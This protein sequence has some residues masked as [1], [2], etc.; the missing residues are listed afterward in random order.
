[1]M[2]LA[3]LQKKSRFGGFRSCVLELSAKAQECAAA[4]ILAGHI[5]VLLQRQYRSWGGEGTA[6]TAVGAV[7]SDG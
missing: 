7:R 6:K 1:M 3:I 5:L 4:W 2:I